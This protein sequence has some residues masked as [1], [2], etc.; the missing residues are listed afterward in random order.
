[1]SGFFA[2]RRE[3]FERARRLTPLGYKIGLELMCK[4]RVENVREVP[5]H[6][7]QRTRGESKLTLKQQFK[8]LEHL[9]RLYD[10]TYPRASPVVKFLIVLAV[11]W[12]A[13][14]GV[15]ALLRRSGEGA[16][17]AT[18]WGYG[19]ALLVTA[20]FHLRYVRT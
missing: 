5:I 4:A 12:L 18:T 10:F 1:M 7:A 19:A 14:L 6:F 16:I 9:S 3:T 17:A 11:S 8:Y 15:F 2:L 13:A 20:G